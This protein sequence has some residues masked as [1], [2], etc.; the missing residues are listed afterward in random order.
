MYF[1]IPASLELNEANIREAVLRMLPIGT[2]AFLIKGKLIGVGI[3]KD[4]LS[5]YTDPDKN[6]QAVIRI[7]YDSKTFGVVKSSYLISLYFST[8]KT[9]QDISVKKWLTGP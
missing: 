7:E 5:S 3:G 1:S 4:G 6:N 2:P 8:T 9:I